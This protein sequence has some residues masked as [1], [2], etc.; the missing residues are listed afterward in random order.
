MSATT[1]VLSL[2][3]VLAVGVVAP[4]AGA[5]ELRNLKVG[6]ALPAFTLNGLDGKVIEHGI[7]EGRTAVLVFVAAHQRSSEAATTEAHAVAR[8][9]RNRDVVLLFVTADV[10]ESVYFRE[11]RDRV[12]VH[13][14]LGLDVDRGLYGALGL[15]VL[16]TTVV[17][18]REGRL[19]HVISSHRSDYPHRLRAYV[20]HALGDIDDEELER[21]LTY[22][23]FR[24]D[25]P[26]DRIA[27]HRA[28]A[29]L[30]R[31]TGLLPDAENELR[32][33]LEID[34]DD[35]GALLDLAALSV[36]LDRL[37][38][39]ET[40]VE[41]VLAAQPKHRRA[42]LVHGIVLYHRDRLDEAEVVLTETL[43]L[44]PDPVYS[45]YYLGLIRERKGD[46]A[47]AAEH[48]RESLGRL[49]VERPF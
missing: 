16:P 27:R 35:P 13:T 23:S 7:L 17:I 41:R 2:L 38:E 21:R 4:R 46:H 31:E 30:L 14:P 8:D 9:L 33:A 5:D 36:A 19:A 32:A 28:A 48:F 42:K 22:E 1:R 49:L 45:H 12:N 15:I 40:L 10:V 34:A 25:R 18:D 20:E 26:E 3:A 37:D 29:K 43:L 44:N 47:A 39:A 11:L 6:D 24:R